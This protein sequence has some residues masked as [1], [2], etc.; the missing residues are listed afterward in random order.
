MATKRRSDDDV[1]RMLHEVLGRYQETLFS[2]ANSKRGESREQYQKRFF[3]ALDGAAINA[4]QATQ[5]IINSYLPDFSAPMSE[6][7]KSFGANY[8]GEEVK[9][10]TYV[11]IV[12]MMTESVNQYKDKLNGEIIR[13]EKE[14]K[15]MTVTDLR[16][17]INADLKND[18]VT[19]VRYANGAKMPVDK[20]AAMLARTSRAETENL[21]MIQQALR[22]GLD[23][24]EC[25][26]VSPT[27]DI[28]AV[29]QNRRYSISG[30]DSRYPALYK[31]A[32]KSGYNIIHPNCRHSWSP[33][34][35]EMYTDEENREKLDATHRSWEPDRNGVHFQQGEKARAEYARGEQLMRQWNAE[36]VDYE[37]MK[38]SYKEK[39]E[40]P[41]YKT[42]GAYRREVRK[43][44][45]KRSSVMQGWKNRG[46]D[47]QQYN[48]WKQA[49]GGKNM[50]ETLEKFQEMKYNK[51]K[52]EEFEL[53]KG[54]KNAQEK[55]D[56]YTLVSFEVY[57]QVS[58]EIDR[59]L[60][61][62][63]FGGIEVK[64]KITHFIDRI[65]EQY[66]E[67][68]YPQ[69]GK[70]QGVKVSEAVETLTSPLTQKTRIKADG[71]KSLTLFGKKCKVTINPETGML[72]QTN[73]YDGDKKK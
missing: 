72:I 17:F 73:P 26:T 52:R 37:R 29:Y 32:F 58:D 31:T 48:R 60:I 2:A 8:G 25:D 42:L 63:T 18:D 44:P 3:K 20:Y 22:E 21:A 67:S 4:R 19:V 1:E 36:L 40:E 46:T 47:E 65:I 49:I 35:E 27:C 23:L 38:V 68:D 12:N 14:G 61:G 10:T 56:I 70:R 34:H 28:C 7:L 51:D 15:V 39:G 59:E 53:L 45:E 43:P 24:V 54:Y 9:L 62:K 5:R 16:D 69:H 13:R 33:V 55:K 41:P 66:Q 11:R 64:G 71:T 57:K 6:L 30:K 50:P